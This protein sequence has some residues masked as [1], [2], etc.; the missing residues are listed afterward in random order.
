MIKGLSEPG[1]HPHTRG[2]ERAFFQSPL[3]FNESDEFLTCSLPMYVT[4]N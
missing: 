4:L 1:Y 3:L 2:I